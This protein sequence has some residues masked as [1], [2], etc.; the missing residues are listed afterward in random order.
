MHFTNRGP[1]HLAQI[2]CSATVRVAPCH[3]RSTGVTAHNYLFP[4][5]NRRNLLAKMTKLPADRESRLVVD[6]LLRR[7]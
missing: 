7:R 2:L 3:Q 6:L 5:I 1:P 4:T